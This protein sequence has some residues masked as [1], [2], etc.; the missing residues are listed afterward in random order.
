[1]PS[2]RKLFIKCKARI[3]LCRREPRKPMFFNAE[4]EHTPGFEP[5]TIGCRARSPSI[6][7]LL[8]LL[9]LRS[10]LML[11]LRM[12]NFKSKRIIAYAFHSQIIY[13]CKARISLCHRIPRKPM[14]SSILK[15]TDRESNPVPLGVEPGALPLG[16]YYSYFIC[17]R[18]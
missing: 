16:H 5:C 15:N 8:I 1:M 9:H 12:N 2:T 3:S 7:P 17:V 4:K 18:V 11:H 6:G 10:S 13:K 14:F